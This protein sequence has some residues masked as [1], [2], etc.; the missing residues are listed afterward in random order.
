MRVSPVMG[1]LMVHKV[2]DLDEMNILR[3]AESLC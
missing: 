2:V 3:K 1:Q